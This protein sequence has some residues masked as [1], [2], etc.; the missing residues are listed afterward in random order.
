[1]DATIERRRA[2]AAITQWREGIERK[3]EKDVQRWSK[4]NN[5]VQLIALQRACGDDVK[6]A[7]EEASDLEFD[8][9]GDSDVTGKLC[10]ELGIPAP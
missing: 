10:Q 6:E 3:Q 1:M 7:A 8:L 9:T 5:L 4:L 2:A